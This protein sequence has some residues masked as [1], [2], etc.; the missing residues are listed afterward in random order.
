VIHHNSPDFLENVI[1]MPSTHK[2]AF[3]QVAASERSVIM[4]RATGPTCHGPLE[5]GYDTK[6]Y[7]IHGK[8]CDWGPMA[9]F[10]LR[11]PRLNKYGMEKLKFN[12]EKH[13]EALVDDHEGQGWLASTTPL[14]ISIHRI[15]WLIEKKII[16]AHFRDGDR[17]DGIAEHK[18]G[19]RFNYSLIRETPVLYGV[20]FD[21]TGLP[22]TGWIQEIGAS[23][24]RHS[25]IYG[26][27]F[28]AML[29]MTNPPE[30]RKHK[31]NHYKNAITGDY[32]L[33]AIWP[34]VG[35]PAAYDA[36]AY[37]LDHRPLGTVK[38]SIGRER[39]RVEKLERDFTEKENPDHRRGQGTKLGNIT[40]RMYMICQLINSIVGSQVLWHS[41][42]AARPFLDDVDLPIMAFTPA[43][44][45][46]GIENIE[47][48]KVWISVCEDMGLKVTL[49]NAWTQDPEGKHTKRL[50]T[51]YRRLVPPDGTR[52]IV[53]RW[54]NA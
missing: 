27:S 39:D 21:N 25:M 18:T 15:K 5:E 54:Y 51:E 48:F 2:D 13:Q 9:G 10:V 28:E 32:D 6:G 17:F 53:P 23:E 3:L 12:R 37:G 20:F 43:G 41:D 14:K 50:G 36:S 42:E 19:I 26:A 35:G 52:I 44:N 31:N 45:Y 29:A 38:G 34:Y 47:D 24:A 49:S 4:V 1:G 7:R 40:P 8:S 16:V 46:F 30:H 33:F 11:D 22:G